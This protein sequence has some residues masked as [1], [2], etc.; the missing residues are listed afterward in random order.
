MVTRHGAGFAFGDRPTL[1]E[2][3][4]IPQI[5]ASSRFEVDL[6]PFPA[7]AAVAK[8]AAAHPAFIAAE[9][10]RQPDAA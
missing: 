10:Q 4:L 6:D 2:C 5:W 8:R 1:A 7:L 3:C 9:P